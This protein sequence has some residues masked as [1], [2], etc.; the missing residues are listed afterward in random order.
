M[1]V[2]P[3]AILLAACSTE[4]KR[5]ETTGSAAATTDPCSPAALKLPDAKPLAPWQPPAGCVLR[6]G[7]PAVLVASDA[8]AAN[9]FDCKDTPL[10]VDFGTHAVV[11][12]HRTLSPATIGVAALDDGKT[13]TLVNKA[14][15]PCPNERPPMPVPATFVFLVAPGDR[16]FA[17]ASCTVQ[18][19]C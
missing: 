1:R 8:E 18:T 7:A 13:V 14:R 2:L 4:S 6:A 17:D 9:V 16:A 10:G 11:V 12:V 19:K 15:N 5:V 3:F